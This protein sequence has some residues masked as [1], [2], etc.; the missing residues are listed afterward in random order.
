MFILEINNMQMSEGKFGINA[1]GEIGRRTTK[2]IVEQHGAERI[3]HINDPFAVRNTLRVVLQNDPRK[4]DGHTVT[5]DKE[6]HITIDGHNIRLTHERDPLN[7]PWHES[8][9][10]LVIDAS[11]VFR[12]KTN[13]GKHRLPRNGAPGNYGPKVL[14]TAPPDGD[15]DNVITYGVNHQTL[16]GE[17]LINS[18]ASC[19]TMCAATLLKALIEGGVDIMEGDLHTVHAYTSDQKLITAVDH[20]DAR[21][22]RGVKGAMIDTSTG[23][24]KALKLV[25]PELK[26]TL[27]ASSTRIDQE[28][29]SK[30]FLNLVLN[31]PTSIEEVHGIIRARLSDKLGIVEIPEDL[32]SRDFIGDPRSSIIDAKFTRMGSSGKFLH[33][34]AWYDNVYA[35]VKRLTELAFAMLEG[36]VDA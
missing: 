32:I 18:A 22:A 31:N 11:G 27:T 21:R 5:T 16:T 19:T 2:E 28:A 13:S 33:I 15:V 35:Y 20:K 1:E 4:W 14:I 8:E 6:G 9:V 34:E 25:L 3:T 7:I 29:V 23:A 10:D 12:N 30:I 17:H 36:K 26:A 24:A